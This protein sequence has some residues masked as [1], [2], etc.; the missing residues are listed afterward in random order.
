MPIKDRAVVEP[1]LARKL[2]PPA[3]FMAN[4]LCSDCVVE[5]VIAGEGDLKVCPKCHAVLWSRY[6]SDELRQRKAELLAAAKARETERRAAQKAM[7]LAAQLSF[8]GR[9]HR[10]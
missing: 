10:C 5:P 4:G 7:R 1:A 8:D 6:S 3:P 2:P 9:D